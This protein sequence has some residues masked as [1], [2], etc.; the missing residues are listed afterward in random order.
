MLRENI[1]KHGNLS[2]WVGVCILLAAGVVGC[3]D[4]N[5]DESLDAPNA[6]AG[7]ENLSGARVGTASWN[8]SDLDDIPPTVCPT[9]ECDPDSQNCAN[10]T[11]TLR[12][13]AT[14]CLPALGTVQEGQSCTGSAQCDVGLACFET[15]TGNRCQRICCPGDDS[16]CAEEEKCGGSGQ[17]LEGTETLT[18]GYCT[19]VRRECDVFDYEATCELG[20]ACYVVSAQGETAC[21]RAGA[22]QVGDSCG[23]KGEAIQNT[24]APTM[25]C[26]A[27]K[28]CQR[29]CG[30]ADES[31]HTCDAD[32]GECVLTGFTPQNVGLCLPL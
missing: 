12:D 13:D 9:D 10:G 16:F 14:V 17:L 18:W 8:G 28:T 20:E 22:A 6:D 24:C 2:R 4:D 19:P 5:S 21:L 29:L 7:P 23:Y 32:E 30:L 25:V 15:S 27:G 3:E 1:Q 31:E 11:C 26:L